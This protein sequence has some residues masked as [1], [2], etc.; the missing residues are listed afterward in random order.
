MITTAIVRGF[1]GIGSFCVLLLPRF[2]MHLP[3]GLLSM[4]SSVFEG[5]GYFVPMDTVAQIM[6]ISLGFS[7]FKFAYNMIAEVR[8]WTPILW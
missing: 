1:I 8:D 3:S 2:D 5:V 4:I 7:V 6:S